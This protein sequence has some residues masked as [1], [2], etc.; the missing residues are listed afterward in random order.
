[1]EQ[2][3]KELKLL[4]E[5]ITAEAVADLMPIPAQKNKTEGL[6]SPKAKHVLLMV[7]DKA[8]GIGELY[9]AVEKSYNGYAITAAAYRNVVAV[10]FKN[11]NDMLDLKETVVREKLADTISRFDEICFLSPSLRQMQA[12]LEGDDSGYMEGLVIYSLLHGK[13]TTIL[14]DYSA[15]SLPMSSFARKIKDMLKSVSEMGIWIDVLQGE[16]DNRA[17]IPVQ[18]KDLITQKEVEDICKTGGK[19]IF[20]TKGCIIT[21]LAKDRARELGIKI[22]DM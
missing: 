15:A 1:M 2:S 22:I 7:S 16:E 10:G 12:L 8:V 18:H 20:R 6:C 3:E 17:G 9:E 21:P 4:I 5:R 19:E 13:K 14:L 11:I